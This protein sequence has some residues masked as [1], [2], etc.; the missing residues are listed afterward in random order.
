[1]TPLF[2]LLL[3]AG[4]ALGGHPLLY[5]SDGERAALTWLRDQAPHDA[6]VLCAPETG[7]FVPAWTGQRVVYGHPFET[8]NAET[9]RAQVE[10]FWAGQ[11]DPAWLDGL[12]VDYLFYGPRERALGE[13]PPGELLFEA[14]DTAVYRR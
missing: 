5:L 6:V 14:G 8:V 9:R 12:G 4:A 7:I 2:L 10:R 11:R 3:G 1:M 13:P